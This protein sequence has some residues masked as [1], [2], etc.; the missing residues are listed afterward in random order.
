MAV[1]TVLKVADMTCSHCEATV[2]QAVQ[3][4]EGVIGVAVNLEAKTVTVTYDEAKTGL[5]AI[6]QAIVDSGYE[7]S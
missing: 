7:V 2:K 5:D 4:V 3:A 1:E 6:K